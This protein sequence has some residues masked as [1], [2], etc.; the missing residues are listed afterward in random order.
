MW[1]N[2]RNRNATAFV[3]GGDAIYADKTRVGETNEV[4]RRLGTPNIFKDHYRQ[5]LAHPEYSKVVEEM[6]IFRT[7]DDHD[8]GVNNGDETYIYERDA[9][10]EFVE[11]FLRLSPDSVMAKGARSGVG[12]YGVK[13]FG[14]EIGQEVLS[15]EE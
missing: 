9:G 8:Y 10:F 2:V 4:G 3:W 11:T 12:V 7:I 1:P 5:Q 13:I 15:D 14:R 6:P